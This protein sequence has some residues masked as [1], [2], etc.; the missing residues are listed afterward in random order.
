MFINLGS[1][2]TLDSTVF[3]G[4]VKYLEITVNGTT[5]TP[6]LPIG[7]VPYA[8]SAGN[9]DNLGGMAPSGVPGPGHRQPVP[10]APSPRSTPTAPSR[11]SAPARPTRNRAGHGERHPHQPQHQWLR[12][13]PG[14]QVQRLE[15]RLR[16]DA[17]TTYTGT[18]PVTVSGTKIGLSTSGCANGQVL[19]YNGSTFACAADVDTNTT[20]AAGT[21]LTL[22]GTT[23]WSIRTPSSTA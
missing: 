22:S 5:M 15:V 16:N 23:F 2:T 6:R 13:R 12:Q 3:N 11:A 19:K 14:A 21:G 9:S 8:L 20:Y 4:G 1:Q 10:L 7:S 18:A 17:N